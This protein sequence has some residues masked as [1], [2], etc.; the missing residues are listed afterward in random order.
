MSPF[1][2]LAGTRSLPE[3]LQRTMGEDARSAAV[4]AVR[5]E[6]DLALPTQRSSV[7]ETMSS[8]MA[9]ADRMNSPRVDPVSCT[10]HLH[11]GCAQD[12][13]GFERSVGPARRRLTGSHRMAR[14]AP[15]QIPR[16]GFAA[17]APTVRTQKPAVTDVAAASL[18]ATDH[19]QGCPEPVCTPTT[20][21]DPKQVGP[22]TRSA[23]PFRRSEAQS[24]SR[25]GVT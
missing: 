20:A 6:H 1:T 10:R 2:G 5:I 24:A 16:E 23:T 15:D 4:T 12:L 25:E 14:S 13:A 11:G 3:G 22:L 21:S 18:P 9:D 19:G 8:T 7:E 17:R